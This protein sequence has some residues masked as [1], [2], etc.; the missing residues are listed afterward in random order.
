MGVKPMDQEG[1]FN[2]DMSKPMMAPEGELDQSIY[3]SG[4]G[5]GVESTDDGSSTAGTFGEPKAAA[6]TRRLAAAESDDGAAKL[7]FRPVV[8]KHDENGIVIK[9]EFDDPD[10]VSTTGTGAVNLAIKAVSIFKTKETMTSLTNDAFKGGKPELGG[11]VPPIISN[12]WEADMIKSNSK[13]STDWLNLFNAGNFFIMLILGGT[14][15]QLWG[16]IRTVQMVTFSTVV[17]VKLPINLFIFLRLY[18]YFAM[19]DVLQGRELYKSILKF[20]EATPF[21]GTFAFFGFYDSNMIN[22]SG[23]YFLI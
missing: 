11:P 5:M 13:T 4:F 1:N 3:G 19:M 2:I 23:S 7:A 17:N 8:S 22:H 15:R 9:V 10:Q 20:G 16:L 18:V 21:N 14:M 6:A 12:E